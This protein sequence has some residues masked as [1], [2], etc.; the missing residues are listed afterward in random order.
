MKIRTTSTPSGNEDGSTGF[1]FVATS[2]LNGL[3]WIR[4]RTAWNSEASTPSVTTTTPQWFFQQ[5]EKTSR[6]RP[7]SGRRISRSDFYNNGPLTVAS[8]EARFA[9]LAAEAYGPV[10][11]L[12]S[13]RWGDYQTAGYTYTR[14]VDWQNRITYDE[15]TYL[16]V[17]TGNRLRA[18]E[19]PPG[20]FPAS[21]RSRV[22]P[23]RRNGRRRI[24][25]STITN[26][27]GSGTIYY[28]L[29]GSEPLNA[30]GTVG[31]TAHAYTS[32]IVLNATTEVKAQ[33]LLGG[34]KAA[35][36]ED[37]T[38]DV[39][40]Q[41]GVT[42]LNYDPGKPA[43]GLTDTD[44]DD[45]EFIE[46]ENFGTTTIN[47]DNVAFTAGISYTF[48]NETLAPGQV[49]VLVHNL[50]A[51]TDGYYGNTSNIDILGSY[52]ASGDSFSNKG[53]EV[54]R[55]STRLPATRSKIL[56]IAPTWYPTTAGN[57]LD[58]GSG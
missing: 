37:A 21:S 43:A 4:R 35:A 34:V 1:Q 31:T 53:E 57:G 40:I 58:F 41:L 23:N 16:P 12:E 20:C 36:A 52:E 13:A 18:I 19:K 32:A 51:F 47:L 22:Q 2:I 28:T 6:I 8:T 56:P 11:P 48:G 38:F 5:L 27:N 14:D 15:N 9:A 30:D 50:A 39:P 46:L 24:R 3:C 25:S 7:R 55:W 29:D 10:V 26:P 33:V 44:S 42:E 17:R 49:G 54:S 45:Y